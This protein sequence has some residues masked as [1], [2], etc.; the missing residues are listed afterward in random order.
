MLPRS[1]GS[2][3]QTQPVDSN[4]AD[5]RRRIWLNP[6][7]ISFSV[8]KIPFTLNRYQNKPVL[9]LTEALQKLR[10]GDM[11]VQD[12]P[13]MSVVSVPYGT[14]SKYYTLDNRRLWIFREYGQKIEVIIEEP[15]DEFCFKLTTVQCAETVCIVDHVEENH[16]FKESSSFL[17][18]VLRWSIDN[19]KDDHY[20]KAQVCPR[21]LEVDRARPNSLFFTST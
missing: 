3:S 14:D 9:T 8:A 1:S 6:N 15:T 5:Q 20:Y 11:K 4:P 18:K 2:T 16:E 19:I 10:R 12:F 13:T 17:S 7:L 21:Q